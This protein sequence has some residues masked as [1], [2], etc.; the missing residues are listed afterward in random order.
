VLV[1]FLGRIDNLLIGL[2]PLRQHFQQRCDRMT[3]RHASGLLKHGFY[4]FLCSL[5][6]CKTGPLIV[7]IPQR[8]TSVFQI[9]LPLFQPV[10]MTTHHSFLSATKKRPHLKLETLQDPL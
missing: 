7:A 8:T 9:P 3:P 5:L 2:Q 4:R 1:Q 6:R 10:R